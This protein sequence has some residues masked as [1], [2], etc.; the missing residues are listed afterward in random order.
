MKRK[1]RTILLAAAF[2]VAAAAPVAALD[3]VRTNSITA[4]TGFYIY[5]ADTMGFFKKHGIDASP[6]WFP[7]GAM[8]LCRVS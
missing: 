5:V 3:Q 1:L 4:Y 2:A 7:S 6:R 8:H